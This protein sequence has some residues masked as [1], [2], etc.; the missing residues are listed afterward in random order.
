MIAR[1]IRLWKCK[2]F[3]L[4][5]RPTNA[6][7][8][9][10]QMDDSPTGH[11]QQQ[12]QHKQPDGPPES[13]Q[14]KMEAIDTNYMFGMILAPLNIYC[15]HNKPRICFELL[16]SVISTLIENQLMTIEYVNEQTMRLLHTEWNQVRE[17][18]FYK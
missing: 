2:K 8:A 11:D 10:A 15:L 7:E 9:Q 1:F 17:F 5:V 6:A 3:A 13:A 12:Q 16:G 18:V 4:F 14:Q